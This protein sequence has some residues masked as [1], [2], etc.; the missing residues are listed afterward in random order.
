MIRPGVTRKR[1]ASAISTSGFEQLQEAQNHN[2]NITSPRMMEDPSQT[3]MRSTFMP[4]NGLS[5]YGNPSN[6]YSSNLYRS[7]YYSGQQAQQ[8]SENLGTE[9]VR[10]QPGNRIVPISNYN[11]GY[12]VA[13]GEFNGPPP[14]VENEYRSQAEY[15]NLDHRALL[16]QRDAHAKRKQIPPFVQK[17]SR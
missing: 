4:T 11:D 2:H 13:T 14:P 8:P 17:L 3:Q 9:L 1:P 5:E 15:D 10:T 6:N 16:A 12:P 7:S